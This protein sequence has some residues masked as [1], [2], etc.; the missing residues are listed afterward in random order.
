VQRA[1]QDI[2]H[3]MADALHV[4]QV[5]SL[6]QTVNVIHPVE[7]RAIIVPVEVVVGV[8]VSAVPPDLS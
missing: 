7:I 2:T 4:L 1:S 8:T 6:V 3:V 5:Q